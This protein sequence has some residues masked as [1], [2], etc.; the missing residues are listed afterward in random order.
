MA[1]APGVSALSHAPASNV[2]CVDDC[3]RGVRLASSCTSV[4]C[5]RMALACTPH[6]PAASI[7]PPTRVLI[8]L[9]ERRPNFLGLISQTAW[10]SE[11]CYLG[12][13]ARWCEPFVI[14][15]RGPSRTSGQCRC[16]SK[17]IRSMGTCCAL[18][19]R[20]LGTKY[21]MGVYSNT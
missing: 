7:V 17:A 2:R 1:V 13:R 12:D 3:A 4:S 5:R 15:A 14:A 18:E 21:Y 8:G 19:L 9:R 11:T 16:T 20:T 6:W 10:K